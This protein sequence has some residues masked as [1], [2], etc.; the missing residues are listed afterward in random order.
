MKYTPNVVY[1]A[2][3]RLSQDAISEI[4]VSVQAAREHT[5]GDV[6]R[7]KVLSESRNVDVANG[8]GR[9]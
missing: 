1:K 9:G 2:I 3:E 7:R 6:A 5:Y 8:M 4:V